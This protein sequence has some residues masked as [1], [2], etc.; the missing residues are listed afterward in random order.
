M[1]L[2]AFLK[3][4]GNANINGESTDSLHSNEIEILSFGHSMG[5]VPREDE[6]GLMLEVLPMVFIKPLDASTPYLLRAA[7]ARTMFTTVTLSL[8]QRPPAVATDAKVNVM[9]IKMETAA[10]SR[11]TMLGSQMMSPLFVQ[12]ASYRFGMPLW[13]SPE[14]AGSG[15]IEQVEVIAR[16]FTWTYNGNSG[17]ANI[18]TV[19]DTAQFNNMLS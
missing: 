15:P 1:L 13:T 10:I 19:Y 5:S 7:C 2:D 12:N 3:I 11:V 8:C 14:I 9:V 16:K 18:Q 17:T 6:N 4:E